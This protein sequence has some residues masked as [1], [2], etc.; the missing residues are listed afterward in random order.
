MPAPAL[1]APSRCPNPDCSDGYVTHAVPVGYGPHAGCD[2]EAFACGV[3]NGRG[4]V[5]AAE[6][7][8][9]AEGFARADFEAA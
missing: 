7:E 4:S 8:R 3:C 5:S 9:W 2:L 1:V 6:A